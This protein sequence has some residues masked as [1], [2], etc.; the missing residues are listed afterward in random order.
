MKKQTG[1][2]T[3][4]SLSLHLLIPI[5][6]ITTLYN[7]PS[8]YAWLDP[9]ATLVPSRFAHLCALATLIHPLCRLYVT[10]LYKPMALTL[11]PYAPSL[12][13]QP[14]RQLL[15]RL[16]KNRAPLQR[17][18]AWRGCERVSLVALPVV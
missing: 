11:P 4:C 10:L 14:N 3:D 7:L 1:T 8:C 17:R 18:H 15:I 16:Y 2:E 9:V 5:V 13:D 6:I 12:I